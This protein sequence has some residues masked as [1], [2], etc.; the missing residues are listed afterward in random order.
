LSKFKKVIFL[1]QIMTMI[2][3]INPKL[4]HIT[5]QKV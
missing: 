3:M 4:N 5:T 1:Y 2:N